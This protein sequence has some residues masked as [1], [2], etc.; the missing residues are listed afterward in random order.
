L[1]EGPQVGVWFRQCIAWWIHNFSITCWANDTRLAALRFA[2]K[3]I[4]YPAAPHVFARLTAF[5]N[6]GAC[7]A[8]HKSWHACS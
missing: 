1:R 3:Q 6:P 8:I 7:Y 4:E 2:E 5:H